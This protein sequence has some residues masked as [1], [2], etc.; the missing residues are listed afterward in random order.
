MGVKIGTADEEVR[1]KIINDGTVFVK[2]LRVRAVADFP[3]YV[4]EDD[5]KLM[6]LSELAEFIK[7]NKHLPNMPTASEVKNGGLAIGDITVRLVEKI[8]ELTL[9]MIQMDEKM[10]AMEKRMSELEK[11]NEELKKTK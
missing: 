11:E 5:Y 7:L 10:S 3:D 8:E 2:E 1:F 9:Y 6:S 4:F